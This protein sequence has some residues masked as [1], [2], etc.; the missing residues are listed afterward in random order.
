MRKNMRG[1]TL[2]ELMMR[3]LI[4]MGKT[5]TEAAVVPLP[6]GWPARGHGEPNKVLAKE[7]GNRGAASP[8]PTKTVS[9]SGGKR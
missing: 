5:I 1:V 7:K 4:D 8:A 2:M 3:E 9:R 6:E